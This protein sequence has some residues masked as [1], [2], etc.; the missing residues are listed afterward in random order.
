MPA[1]LAGKLPHTVLTHKEAV[2]CALGELCSLLPACCCGLQVVFSYTPSPTVQPVLR[3]LSFLA[4]GGRSLAVVGSTGS[5]KSTLLRYV[6]APPRRCRTH[7]STAGRLQM[8]VNRL[9]R[10]P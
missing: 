7:A 9:C 2:L 1:L 5:G 4:P 6:G 3:S 10:W 8:L